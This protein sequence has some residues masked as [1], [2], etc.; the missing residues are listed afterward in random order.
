MLSE[1]ASFE[2]RILLF[3]A[4]CC[5]GSGTVM[6]H[7]FHVHDLFFCFCFVSFSSHAAL[8]YVSSHLRI[9]IP[10]VDRIPPACRYCRSQL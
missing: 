2:L 10:F 8:F 3:E 7:E 1:I 5:S 4:G 6:R 9:Y